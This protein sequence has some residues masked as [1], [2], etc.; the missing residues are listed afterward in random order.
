MAVKVRLPQLGKT[1]EE[2]TIVGYMVKPGDEVKKGDILFEIETDKVTLEVE[3]PTD[4]FVKHILVET[5]QTLPVG[6]T[7]LILA[8]E[9]EQVPPSFISSA[10]TLAP[11]QAPAVQSSPPA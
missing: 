5:D 10:D 3:S 11:A 4:G 7:V 8:D 1:M 9:D 6:E 2:G